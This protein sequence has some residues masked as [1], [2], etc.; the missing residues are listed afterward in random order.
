VGDIQLLT[1]RNGLQ[2]LLV[3]RP[4]APTVS[5]TIGVRGGSA[6]AEPLGVPPLAI[7]LS[8]PLQTGNG[9]PSQF[10]G[11]IGYA[12]EA[13]AS[14]VE[15]RAASGNLENLLAVLSDTVQ[16]LHVDDDAVWGWN[17]LVDNKRRSDAS[18]NAEAQRRFIAEV[19]PGSAMGRTAVAANVEKLGPGDLNRWMDKAFRPHNAAL[20]V[21]GDIDLKEA[22]KQVHTYFDSWKGAANPKAE[23]PLGK[24]TERIGPV[25]VIAINRPGAQETEIRIGCSVNPQSQT[26]L[27]ALRILGSRLRTKLGTLARGALGG[28]DGFSGGSDFQRQAA[29]LD[30]AGSV[31]ERALVPVLAAARQELAALDDYKP[32]DDELALLKWRQGIAWNGSYTT[33]AELAKELVWTRLADLPMNLLQ[34]YPELLAALTPQDLTRVAAECRKTAVLM[35]SGDPAIVDKALLATESSAMLRRGS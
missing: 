20:A 24:V 16:S 10:G 15:G 17:A 31:D 28:S 11:S 1:L 27:T 35:V 4:G 13:D 25:Q 26:D 23:V 9:P 34:S 30:V 7:L 8:R 29:R 5:A 33:N 6:T 3:R 14:Y 2:V 18:P 19:Y 32:T 21:V 12:I 22:E